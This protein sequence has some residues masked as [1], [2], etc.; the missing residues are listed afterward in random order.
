M[1]LIVL[2]PH[3]KK[4]KLLVGFYLTYNREERLVPVVQVVHTES[5][6]VLEIFD[7]KIYDHIALGY[8]ID[9]KLKLNEREVSIYGEFEMTKLV[10]S[11]Y[12]TRR[13]ISPDKWHIKCLNLSELKNK[14]ILAWKYIII[15]P[16]GEI[17][18]E[19]VSN[20]IITTTS[21]EIIQIDYV[22]RTIEP[23]HWRPWMDMLAVS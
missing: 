5:G 15:Y 7:K 16:S 11:I 3:I 17:S 12:E 1:S 22:W 8:F 10:L 13:Y 14:F 18:L 19:V 2:Y 9:G 23:C 20:D 4:Y 21:L 6:Q